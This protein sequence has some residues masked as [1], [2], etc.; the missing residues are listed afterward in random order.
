MRQASFGEQEN[1]LQPQ[2]HLGVVGK[3]VLFSPELPQESAVT[4]QTHNRV[5][6]IPNLGGTWPQET[7]MEREGQSQG[8]PEV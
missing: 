5:C 4:G 2:A 3:A 7:V 8:S 1:L 6:G